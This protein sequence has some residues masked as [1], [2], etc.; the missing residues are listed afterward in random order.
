MIPE[1][2]TD[3][4]TA[5]VHARM[6]APDAKGM[7]QFNNEA[8]AD[9]RR[10][11]TNNMTLP[12]RTESSRSSRSRNIDNGVTGVFS[13]PQIRSEDQMDKNSYLAKHNK[14]KKTIDNA[15]QKRERVTSH[16]AP[17][18]YQCGQKFTLCE[19]DILVESRHRN[20]ELKRFVG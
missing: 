17:E 11:D 19:T 8:Q 16:I 6:D 18:F 1:L 7:V 3:A 10:I 4:P 15:K 12:T 20:I 14:R 5:I 9:V 13:K 2:E